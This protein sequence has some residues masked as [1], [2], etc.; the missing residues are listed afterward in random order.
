MSSQ[1]SAP[2]FQDIVDDILENINGSKI[3]RYE[4]E[5]YEV[6]ID[7]KSGETFTSISGYARMGRRDKTTIRRRVQGGGGNPVKTVEVPTAGGL[8]GVT[9]VSEK[10]IAEWLPKD[11]PDLATKMLEQGIRMF[12]YKV[13][14]YKPKIEKKV[15]LEPAVVSLPDNFTIREYCAYNRL[16]LKPGVRQ[17]LALKVLSHYRAFENE[18]PP[19]KR[20]RVKRNLTYCYP[21]SY[22]KFIGNLLETI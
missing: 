14:G 12:N 1:I 4:R 5:G 17:T 13:V 16:S 3:K 10:Q 8:Q 21:H 22:V 7:Q 9:M 11:N 2:G 15:N 19:M 18:S 6:Y 20:C